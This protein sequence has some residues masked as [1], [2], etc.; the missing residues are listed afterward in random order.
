MTKVNIFI[1]RRTKKRKYYPEA[2]DLIPYLRE[3]IENIILLYTDYPNINI[4]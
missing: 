1:F 4:G 3:V 2:L